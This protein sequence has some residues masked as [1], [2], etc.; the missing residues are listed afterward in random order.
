MSILILVLLVVIVVSGHQLFLALSQGRIYGRDG[1]F[2]YTTGWIYAEE[3]SNIFK[4]TT[5]I[6]G[7]AFIGAIVVFVM[8]LLN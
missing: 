3:K 8:S 6:Y 2:S 7:M 1:W 4:V 5:A